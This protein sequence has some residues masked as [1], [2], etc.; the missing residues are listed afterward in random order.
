MDIKNPSAH[1]CKQTD[2]C[3]LR[4]KI[5][6]LWSYLIDTLNQILVNVISITERHT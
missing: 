6:E 5:L 4:H 1:G 2:F 3:A